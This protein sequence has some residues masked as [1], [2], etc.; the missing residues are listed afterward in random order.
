MIGRSSRN[1][2]RSFG[3]EPGPASRV[4]QAHPDGASWEQ[5]L[6]RSFL[7]SSS[8]DVVFFKDRESRF[9]AA[10]RSFWTYL[11]LE[12]EADVL[13]KTDFDFFPYEFASRTFAAEQEIIRTGK[14]QVKDEVTL[15]APDGTV[16][17][18]ESSKW[19]LLGNNGQIVGTCC[20]SRDTTT[21][22]LN[23]IALRQ[24]TDLLVRIV[25][26][27]RLVATAD[28]DLLA[29][30]QLICE[31][32]Q[33]LTRADGACI[34]MLEE[35]ALVYRAASGFVAPN[36]GCLIP[37]ENTFS[38]WVH[39][40]G[41]PAIARDSHADD[42]FDRTLTRRHEIRSMVGVPLRHG[43]RIAGQLQ[44]LSK[45]P[46][47]FGDET[48]HTLELL[49]VVLAASLSHSAEFEAK[50]AEVE[51][52]G[53]FATVFESAPIG[54]AR[55]DAAGRIVEANPALI[56]MLGHSEEELA[57]M[58]FEQCTHPEDFEPGRMLFR[59]L[60]D[61]TRDSYQLEQRLFRKDGG[62]LWA[63]VTARLARHE[64]GSPA[65]AIA[66]V[67]DITR[68][69]TAEEALIREAERNHHQAL[70]DALTGLANRRLFRDRIG[71][72]I[73]LAS[74][75]SQRAA[76]MM[77][78]LDRFKEINDSLGHEAG[79][80]LL[81][82]LGERLLHA[83]RVS[84][85]V[86]R[87]GGD[88]FGILLTGRCEKDEIVTLI[89][90]IRDAVEEPVLLHELPVSMEA[91]IGVAFY[92]DDGEDVDTLL[93]HADVAMYAAKRGNTTYAFYDKVTDAH[94]P[95]RLTLVGEL[96]RALDRRELV[97]HYQPKALLATG[98]VASAEALLRW[99]HPLRGLVQ[100][101]EFIPAAQETS[102]IKPLTLYVIE[103]ALAQCR[104]WR[105]AGIELSVAVNLSM[106]NLL[107]VAFP[108]QV[109]RLLRRSGIPPSALE[110]EIT[111]STMLADPA[112][113]R[114]VL[115][116]LSAI[117]IRLAIDDFGTGYSSLSYI[118]RLPI[119]EIKIDRSFVTNMVDDEDDAAIVRSTIDLGKN[120]GLDVVAEGVE[121][122]EIWERLSNLGCTIAQG[123]FLSRPVPAGDLE[124]WLRQ[125]PELSVAA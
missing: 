14:P 93:R 111:E 90:R 29:V 12:S 26:L 57:G 46:H 97:L 1:R 53:R 42:R 76:V 71:N 45:R 34:L 64:D 96:R 32:T 121:T 104:G 112:R 47:S 69:K 74:R 114:A 49:S 80:A 81:K 115:E 35:G 48:L 119:D 103:E 21:R 62:L 4:E 106:R 18:I 120:L 30:M 28:L 52:L 41:Q 37:L 82:E 36:I 58:R 83:V 75:H 99:Q 95:S 108:D 13:G 55:M 11:G 98:E 89:H 122:R 100:P 125:R 73:H 85:T 110:M 20:V 60:M 87:L 24:Q 84:D 54:L 72:G 63:Q 5:R 117:G 8:S 86:A 124:R 107:D 56:R 10:S 17:W 38:G 39:R 88:E 50:R 79:D 61:G 16:K 2:R 92:P 77:M 68:R 7:D 65:Y 113:V 70:H 25:E 15:P 78:D 105:E 9:I 59:E 102:L 27:Q 3:G 31:Q 67:E 51:A 118:K 40:H 22:K 19:P 43:E 123:N 6:L 109:E 101:D 66:M 44:V 116:Q 23:E 91:S 33:Q 94:N